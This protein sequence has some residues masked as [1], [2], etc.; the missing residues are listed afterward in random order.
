M[1]NTGHTLK[2]AIEDI[3]NDRCYVPDE[4]FVG[5]L[6]TRLLTEQ[7]NSS[8]T[9]AANIFTLRNFA[10]GFSAVLL[11]IF[12]YYIFRQPAQKS[13]ISI[14]YAKEEIQK[15]IQLLS[16]PNIIVHR[17]NRL[18]F[19]SDGIQTSQITYELWEDNSSN[20]FKN[21]AYYSDETVTQVNDGSIQWN[22]SDREKTLVKERYKYGNETTPSAAPQS[23]RVE[24][25]SDFEAILQ[26]DDSR[27][28]LS[29][30][31]YNNN[32][33][34]ILETVGRVE[35]S[36]ESY[37]KKEKMYFDRNS[38]KL[39]GTREY[40]VDG[41]NEYLLTDN[42]ELIYEAVERTDENMQSLFTF[43]VSLPADTIITE[44]TIL[45][46]ATNSIELPEVAET[47]PSVY[48][49]TPSFTE[50]D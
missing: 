13:M 19:Y 1:N 31:L 35:N 44:R 32:P 37:N 20:K 5:E 4:L 28:T 26:Y 46:S 39:I 9:S 30:G 12:G 34:Y 29:E 45:L 6:H 18:T 27:I 10:F 36:F 21:S 38:M 3:K 49:T 8:N 15:Q 25:L 24:L 48:E 16:D 7:K 11:I 23:K 43:T 22:Y 33:V 2:S 40:R 47:N 41:A 50:I 42:E 14:A 17:K